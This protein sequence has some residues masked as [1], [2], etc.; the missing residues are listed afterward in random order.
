MSKDMNNGKEGFGMK[1]AGM[2]LERE[3]QA[4]RERSFK[5][6]DKSTKCCH[7]AKQGK[8]DLNPEYMLVELACQK[9][10][11][12]C[13]HSSS[14]RPKLNLE[15][16]NDVGRVIGLEP[17]GDLDDKASFE[18][19]SAS[20]SFAGNLRGGGH[21]STRAPHLSFKF[22]GMVAFLFTFF[23]GFR[24]ILRRH[25]KVLKSKGHSK[26]SKDEY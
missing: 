21:K 9:S 24:Y 16:I 23:I 2:D 11:S 13:G 25:S 4:N 18:S 1:L 12:L 7:E 19:V 14:C 17:V 26:F 5:C 10:C 20:G 8:C 15:D 22:M 6:E 3:I